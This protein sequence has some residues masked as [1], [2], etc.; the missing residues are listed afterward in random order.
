MLIKS[1]LL[2]G[3]LVSGGAEEEQTEKVNPPILVQQE[4]SP[5][6][7]GTM[8]IPYDHDPDWFYKKP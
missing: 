1:V 8:W 6:T 2:V 4:E 7:V 3:S 5:T